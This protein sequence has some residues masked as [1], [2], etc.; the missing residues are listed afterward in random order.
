MYIQVT[1][2]NKVGKKRHIIESLTEKSHN[3]VKKRHKSNV[4]LDDKKSQ[5]SERSDK[6]V[7]KKNGK[8]SQTSEKK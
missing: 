6:L 5:N 1:K 2:S 7:K 3:I 4:N 8:K